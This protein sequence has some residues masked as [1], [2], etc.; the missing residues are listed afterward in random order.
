MTPRLA[1]AAIAL[2][3]LA[4]CGPIPVEQAERVCLDQARGAAGPRSQVSMGVA[5]DG[6]RVR[7]VAGIELAISSDWIAGRDPAQAF[8]RCVVNRSGQMPTR[9]LSQ[10]PGWIGRQ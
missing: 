10:Q 6:H 5:T 9:P 8:D 7:P 4:A 1:L 3:G 2:A